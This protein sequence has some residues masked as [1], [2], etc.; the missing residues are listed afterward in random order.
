ML[1]QGTATDLSGTTVNVSGGAG[2]TAGGGGRFLLGT[3]A[4]ISSGT[5]TGAASTATGSGSTDTN[6]F[7]GTLP[8]TPFIPNLPTVGSE[9]YGLTSLTAAGLLGSLPATDINGFSLAGASAASSAPALGP[10][11]GLHRL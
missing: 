10:R 2:G 9:I 1:I 8:Q 7:V 4:A 5:V 3:N 6:P 11:T